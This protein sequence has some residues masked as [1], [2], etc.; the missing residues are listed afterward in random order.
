MP[1]KPKKKM[2]LEL[3]DEVCCPHCKL[4]IAYVTKTIGRDTPLKADMFLGPGIV[5]GAEMK[6]T[7]C[8]MPWF[9][10]QTTQ[11]HTRSHGWGPQF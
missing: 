9:L 3:G 8:G 7:R 2:Q 10:Q 5:R 1:N 4:H 11:I 6:C